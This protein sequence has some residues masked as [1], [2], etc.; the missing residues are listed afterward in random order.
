MLVTLLRVMR[1]QEASEMVMNRTVGAEL[2]RVGRPRAGAG[3]TRKDI[4]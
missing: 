3:R 4:R 1:N 2:M